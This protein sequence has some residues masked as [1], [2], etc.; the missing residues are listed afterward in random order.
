M[1]DDLPPGTYQSNGLNI[2]RGSTGSFPGHGLLGNCS[3]ALYFREL[4]CTEHS[5][6]IWLGCR[7]RRF[8][9]PFRN[10]Y[11]ILYFVQC[12]ESLRA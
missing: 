1:I 11:R 12:D 7:S 9:Y 2:S 6:S 4:A 3:N 8:S 10:H 5:W